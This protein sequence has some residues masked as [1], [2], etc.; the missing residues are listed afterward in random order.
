MYPAVSY[1]HLDE[2][3]LIKRIFEFEEFKTEYL[4]YACELIQTNFTLEHLGQFILDRHNLIDEVYKIDTYRT[5]S[6][7][8]F[9]NSLTNDNNDEVSLT[10]SGYVLRLRYPGIYP[11]IQMQREWV[12]DQLKGWEKTCN[13]KDNSLYTLDV[14]PNPSSDYVNISNEGGGFEYAQFRLYDFTGKLCMATDFELMEGGFHYLQLK[15]LPKGIYLLMKY[16]AD[17]RRGRAK[18]VIQ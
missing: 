13:I 7:S 15:T 6:Y 18:I 14:F 3:P 17:G 12:V 11:F 5:N 4:N 8:A 16:S 1:T 10:K 2:R 9:K